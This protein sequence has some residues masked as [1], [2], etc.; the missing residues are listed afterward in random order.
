MG[1]PE[2]LRLEPAAAEP[3]A[4]AAEPPASAKP[5]AGPPP[6]AGTDPILP[7]T[8]QQA[9]AIG[10]RGRDVFLEA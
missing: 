7:P 10:E 8:A 1:E 6:V 5:G 4:A 3:G 2:Q 9:R